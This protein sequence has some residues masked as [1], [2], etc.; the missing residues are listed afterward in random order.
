MLNTH[1]MIVAS[2][3]IDETPSG[4]HFFD[5]VLLVRW[6]VRFIKGMFQYRLVFLNDV[7]PL[8]IVSMAYSKSSILQLP[9]GPINCLITLV[10][11]YHGCD[12]G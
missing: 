12:L 10:D 7:N 1:S 6:F 2:S 4:P 3:S 11:F 8:S 9:L 5:I